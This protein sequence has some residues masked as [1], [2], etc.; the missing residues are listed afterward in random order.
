MSLWTGALFGFA[1]SPYHVHACF[2]QALIQALINESGKIHRIDI[3]DIQNEDLIEWEY[4]RHHLDAVRMPLGY[5]MKPNKQACHTQLNPC[6]TCRNLCTTPDFLPQYELEMRETKVLIERGKAQ[7][8]T[9]WV[10]KNQ[11]LLGRYETIVAE[12]KNGN[13]HHQAGKTGREY[14]GEERN[15]GRNP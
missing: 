5:C 7:G 3:T 10:E 2:F 15:N 4:I 13:I 6:L 1:S 14:R 11:V 8:R 9:L 12:L